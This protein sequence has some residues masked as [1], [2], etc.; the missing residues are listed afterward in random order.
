MKILLVGINAKYIH[1]NSAVRSL[2]QYYLTHESIHPKAEVSIAEFTINQSRA[3]IL[4]E[5]VL[6]RP[7]A[8]GFSCYIWNWRL[9]Q[10]L[11]VEL[12]V[13]LPNA[14]IF[15]GGPEVSYEPEDILRET[16]VDG[17]LC[18]EGEESFAALADCLAG[19]NSAL[20]ADDETLGGIPGLARWIDGKYYAAPPVVPLSLDQ[21]PLPYTD[22]DCPAER[23]IYYESSRGCPF[24]CQYCLSSIEG[25]V[26]YKSSDRVYAELQFFLDHRVRQVKFVD[27]T[28]NCQDQ[29]A[30]EIISYL[31]HHDN[32][33]TNFHFEIAGEL[34]TDAFC[35]LVGTAR[36]GLLQFEIGVQ[37]TYSNTL[38]AVQRKTDMEKLT[39]VVH[40]LKAQ[41]NVHLHLDLI[42][43]LPHEG[44]SRFAQSFDDV[45]ALRPDQLQLGFLKLLRGSGLRR[46]K[47][48][49]GLAASPEPPYEIL[50]TD[51]LSYPEIL[52]LKQVENMVEIYYNS[53]R[54]RQ[55]IAYLLTQHPSPF[56]MFEA[57]GDA[58]DRRGYHQKSLSKLEV[59]DF[60]YDFCLDC[61]GHEELFRWCIRYDLYSHEKANKLPTWLGQGLN[62][63]YRDRIRGFYH[64]SDNIQ[65][66][67]PEYIG[68]EPKRISRM[69]HIEVFPKEPTGD[70]SNTQAVLFNYRHIDILG[71]AQTQIVPI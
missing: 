22:A 57:M 23:I 46:D 65:Q 53:N 31:I 27:R 2:Q 15:Y 51:A 67:L 26:R 34:V 18:G 4:R 70:P 37:S 62:H 50:Q 14:Y 41:E 52:R 16:G 60:L 63:L 3:L 45:F 49:Y 59:F 1:T 24:A 55:S 12:R 42:A 5:I 36:K 61:G 35:Q 11:T 21:L 39:Q 48:T 44:Y 47:D 33:V 30:R 43:G 20:K 19:R 66:Y 40:T 10:Q 13:V 25:G 68:L 58:Y 6:T 38:Q 29:R 71:N 28:F 54:F 32:G 56:A 8:V 69:A 17:I 7:D 9:V 64:N